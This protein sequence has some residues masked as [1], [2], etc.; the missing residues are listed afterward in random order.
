LQRLLI[1]ILGGA[2][3]VIGDM[4]VALES[5]FG[6]GPGI[7]V[8]AGTGSIGFGR[9][10]EGES[11]RAGGWGRI[12]CDEGSAHWIVIQAI[13]SALHDF[14]RG[15]GP[16]LLHQLLEALDLQTASDLAAY[17][18][19]TPTPEFAPLFAEVLAA[20]EQKDPIACAVLC[21]AGVELAGLANT[22]AE[23]L[24]SGASEI[25]VATHGGVFAASAMVKTTFAARLR[26]ICPGARVLDVA[27]DPALGALNR[28]RREFGI[29]HK[30]AN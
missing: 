10:R 23:R 2:I 21:R 13:D 7:V 1:E 3:E 17:A 22:V 14:D 11:A 9:N 28:A 27:V 15:R 6:G 16:K 29:W 30:N 5:A 8:V 24:F 26:E 12:L 19:G 25:Q 20:A 18:G 4:E